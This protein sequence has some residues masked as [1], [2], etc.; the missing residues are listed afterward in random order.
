[1]KIS[2]ITVN[3]NNLFGLAMTIRSVIGQDYPDIEYIVIDGGSD[4]G[5][6]ELIEQYRDKITYWVSEADNGI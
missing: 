1:M 5:S 2:I 3:Y 6:R 4:D